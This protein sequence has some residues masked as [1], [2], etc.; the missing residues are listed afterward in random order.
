MELSYDRSALQEY[1]DD[2]LGIGETM[3]REKDESSTAY[4]SCQQ[5]YSRLYSEFEQEN[6]KA[7]NL[8]EAAESM[9]RSADA[10]YEVALRIMENSEDENG[11]QLAQQ[12][13]MRAQSM[14]AEAEAEMA[15]ASAQYSK[16]QANMKNLT[17]VWG[18]YQTQLDSCAHRVE[19]GLS[20]FYIVMENGNRDLGEYMSIMDKAQ[21]SLHDGDTAVES[22]N[23]NS[24]YSLTNAGIM[25]GAT[26]GRTTSGGKISPNNSLE[27]AS[28]SGSDSI[29]MNIDGKQYSFPNNKSGAAKAYRLA[30]K[31]GD[32]SLI[33]QTESLFKFGRTSKSQTQ[34]DRWNTEYMPLVKANIRQSVAANFSE[35]VSQEKMEE[36]LEALGFMDQDELR[37]RYEE[38][39]GHMPKGVLGY[40]D[41]ESSNIASDMKGMTSDGRV[42]DFRIQGS[43][44][45]PINY[46]FVTAVHE[47]LHMMSAN[48]QLGENRRGIMVGNDEQSRA[49]N[50]A[51]TEYFTFISCGGEDALGGLYPG[52]YSGYQVL[53]QEMPTIEKAVG[54][55]CMME[56]YFRNNPQRIRAE[57]DRV[58]ETGAWDDMC[59]ASYDLLY[60]DNSNGGARRLVKYFGRLKQ[61]SNTQQ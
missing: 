46:A 18:K 51:F 44:G 56:A 6:R 13:I 59:N 60:N 17:D 22:T 28:S 3:R 37:R 23:S 55:D 50:E 25:V 4:K 12:Q 9:R 15:V 49:M 29:I 32:S 53:M 16:A 61:V 33:E 45:T 10:E 52:A 48:D 58:L 19:D 54:R 42:G 57:I 47:N 8:V 2:M 41:G 31:S 35:Y 27:I 11:V 36:C 24:G 34:T 43:G 5:Y 7:Y 38:G 39:G 14:R 26:L 21:M 1:M 40:N 20:S 30:M